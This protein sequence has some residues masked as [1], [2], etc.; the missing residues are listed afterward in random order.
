[1]A[2]IDKIY[3]DGRQHQELWEWIQKNKP[4]FCKYM[5]PPNEMSHLWENTERGVSNFP[6]YA[7]KWLMKHCDIPWVV[8][9]ICKQY[10]LKPSDT[11]PKPKTVKVNRR[12]I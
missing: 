10:G 2:A 9:Y 3:C 11:N 7:D 6:E 12:K 4:E 5:Y 1:M 8:E